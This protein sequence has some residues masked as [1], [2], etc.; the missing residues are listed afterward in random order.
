LRAEGISCGLCVLYACLGI[1]KFQLFIQKLYYF[2]PAVIFL[3][4]LVIKTLDLELDPDPDPYLDL[5]P[6]MELGKM[7]YADPDTQ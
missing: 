6:D 1:I 3:Q 4:F 5:D 2:N 7:L